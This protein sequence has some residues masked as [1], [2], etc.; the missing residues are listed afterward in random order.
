MDVSIVVPVYNEAAGLPELLKRLTQVLD[1]IRIGV[2]SHLGGRRQ[3]RFVTRS[4]RGVPSS[5]SPNLRVCSSAAI[6]AIKQPSVPDCSI[7]RGNIVAVMDGDLQDPP[8]ILPK[9]LEQAQRGIRRGVRGP[10]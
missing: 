3:Q 8:E 2:R 9:F 10:P 1:A 7:A 5:R 6:L 4:H